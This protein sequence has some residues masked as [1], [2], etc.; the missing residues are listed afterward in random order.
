ML[1]YD[2][3]IDLIG[4]YAPL[5]GTI[6][7]YG[8]INSLL[9][10]SYTV[11]DLGAGRGTWFFADKSEYRRRLR[12]IKGKV[13]TFIGADVD[14]AVLSNQTTDENLL[15]EEGRIPLPDS[16]VDVIICD[17]VLEHIAN[18]TRFELEVYRVLKSGGFFCAR[19]PH[20]LHYVSVAARCI[21]DINHSRV[22]KLIQPRRKSEDTF[23]TAYK[24]NTM[25][26]VSRYWGND[27]WKHFSYIYCPHPS[28]YFDNRLVYC[29]LS[30]MHKILP[31][32]L[33]ANILVFLEKK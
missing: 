30:A 33:S 29:F 24:C 26:A 18:P 16:S 3:S 23:P 6:E 11:L 14:E 19:T 2:P 28:Y 7:F 13:Q 1:S 25:R 21:S 9:K 5:D 32:L 10:P 4:H 12:S 17:F 15:I 20:L 31:R 8:R 22:L 27:R